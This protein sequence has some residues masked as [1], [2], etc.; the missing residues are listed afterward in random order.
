[1]EI[2]SKTSA[3]RDDELNSRYRFEAAHI[4]FDYL[5]KLINEKYGNNSYKKGED[6]SWLAFAIVDNGIYIAD[7]T[8]WWLN[9]NLT[10]TFDEQKRE[11]NL[12]REIWVNEKVYNNIPIINVEE[13]LNNVEDKIKGQY[14]S[15]IDSTRSEISKAISDMFWDNWSESKWKSFFRR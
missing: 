4:R 3:I 11:F 10:L 5:K 6:I 14:N 13:F 2:R 9:H 15:M 1:M 7:Y 12:S 8:L